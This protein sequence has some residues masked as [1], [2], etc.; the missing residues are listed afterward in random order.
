MKSLCH[1][2]K[3]LCIWLIF[4][5]KNDEKS[6]PFDADLR[7]IG[8]DLIAYAEREIRIE[9]GVLHL[10]FCSLDG[11]VMTSAVIR[12]HGKIPCFLSFGQ[13]DASRKKKGFV[14]LGKQMGTD[15]VCFAKGE[16]LQIGKGMVKSAADTAEDRDII[17]PLLHRVFYAKHG[18]G[19]VLFAGNGHGIFRALFGADVLTV[20]EIADD[21]MRRDMLLLRRKIGAVSAE[22]EVVCGNIRDLS[23]VGREIGRNDEGVHMCILS[24]FGFF[25]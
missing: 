9:R 21:D 8:S 25:I 13:T 19:I 5:G 1:T 23:D 11:N 3:A 20:I 22:N 17:S 15:A 14:M 18:V 6:A 24:V 4:F 12:E 2:A 10:V 7:E 16:R